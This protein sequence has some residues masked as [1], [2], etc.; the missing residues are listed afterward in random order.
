MNLVNEV[1]S[2]MDL[3][4]KRNDPNSTLGQVRNCM[5]EGLDKEGQKRLRQLEEAQSWA[6]EEFT[7]LIT[8]I[9]EQAKETGARCAYFQYEDDYGQYWHNAEY[10]KGLALVSLFLAEGFTVKTQFHSDY[11]RWELI[12]IWAGVEFK[13]E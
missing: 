5:E 10:Q 12:I 2:L 1:I 7:V 8:K 13:N 4:R 6:K 11:H 3:F 9:K